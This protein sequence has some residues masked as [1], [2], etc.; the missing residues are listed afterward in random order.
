MTYY[1]VNDKNFV[2]LGLARSGLATV[3][4]LIA[5]GAH[6]YAYDKDLQKAQEAKEFGAQLL[7]PE[8]IDWSTIAALVHSPGIS[9]SHS[10]S[11]AAIN[12]G[13][14]LITDCNLLRLTYPKTKFVGVT[15]TNG[16]S[17]TTTLIGHILQEAGRKAAIGGNVG[18]PALSLPAL[19]NYDYFVLELS[20]YQLELS[21]PLSLDVMAWLNISED[22]LERHGTME[23]YVKAKRRIFATTKERGQAVISVDDPWSHQV[24]QNLCNDSHP[25][26]PISCVHPLDYGVYVE[27]G[28]LVDRLQSKIERI[29]LLKDIETLQGTHN[30]QNIAITYA[31]CFSLGLTKE[32]I[33]QG[34]KSFPGLAHRQELVTTLKGIKFINDSKATNADATAKA[35]ATYDHIYWIVGGQDKSDGIEPLKDYFP[36]IRH[37]FLIGAAMNRFAQTLQGHVEVT[38]S[39]DLVTAL[40]QA[41]EKAQNEL[42]APGVILL[43]PACASFDQF[44]DFEHRGN[45]FREQVKKLEEQGC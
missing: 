8:D 4:W 30:S 37:A 19:G 23:N 38:L 13:V 25:V 34:L 22:H 10:V 20:S 27:K 26:I 45:T 35:L 1:P 43:S 2:V 16:K 36:K 18:V 32:E 9:P 24:Y 29:L 3:Q 41:Y 40:R 6:V 42:D 5:E 12:H 39:G 33:I 15:G 7:I 17:T 14:P 11:Q 44:V 21:D 31:V 28:T